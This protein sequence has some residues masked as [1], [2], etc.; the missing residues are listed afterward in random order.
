MNMQDKHVFAG[1]VERHRDMVFRIAYTYMR[2]AADADDVTQAVFL[3]LYRSKVPFESEEHVC[4]WL[5][6]VTANECKSLFR[7]PWRRVEDI[8]EYASTLAMPTEEHK[9]LFVS[10]MRLPERY[11]V[12]LVLY[13][14]G[15]LSTDEVAMVLSL[16]PPAVRTRLARARAKLK[17]II[18]EESHE[19]GAQDSRDDG[20]P[21]RI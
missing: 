12:P 13:Y 11:R 16:K 7:K 5:A 9:G 4:N 3:K 21:A 18:E 8:E 14:Y 17:T 2:D 20:V 10:I 1:V 6:K 19:P 15:G